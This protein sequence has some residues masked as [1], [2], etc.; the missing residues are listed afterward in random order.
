[1]ERCTRALL[2]RQE[3]KNDVRFIRVC[4]TYA[5]KTSS[6]ADVFQILASTLGGNTNGTLLD[7][8]GVGGGKEGRL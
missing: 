3:Y 2:H 1:M 4:V 6:P 5:D 8:M 7:G